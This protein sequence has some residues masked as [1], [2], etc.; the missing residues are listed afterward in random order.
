MNE[1]LHAM[2]GKRA[3]KEFFKSVIIGLVG[4]VLDF[5]VTAVILYLEGRGEYTGFW[6]IVTGATVSGS[7]HKTPISIYLTANMLGF[8][9]SVVFN[10]VT[11]CFFVYEYGNVGRNK[12]GF[13]KFLLFALI[14]LAIT[15][16]G[17][18]VGYGALGGNVWI[19]KIVAMIL[20]A[21]FNF[22]TRKYFVFNVALIRD[23]ENTIQL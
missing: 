17:S 14:G 1:F 12:K 22:F 4:G 16:I 10:Y 19:V 9:V 13:L 18:A 6:S 3:R 2:K 8:A 7:P 11:C 5:L 21:V 15:T 23:D 20:V